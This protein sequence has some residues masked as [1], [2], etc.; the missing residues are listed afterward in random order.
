MAST[1]YGNGFKVTSLSATSAVFELIGGKYGVTILNGDGAG[2]AKLQILGPD[3]ST[4]VDV[5]ATTNV[6]NADK[7]AAVD[8]PACQ[9]KLT[10]A[11]S[12]GVAANCIPISNH[13]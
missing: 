8:L 7:Y 10:I 12:T 9:V 4:Y 1:N 13:R 5:G 11:T 3:G 2:S 6:T